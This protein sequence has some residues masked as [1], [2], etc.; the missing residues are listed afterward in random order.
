MLRGA[1]GRSEW[2]SVCLFLSVCSLLPWVGRDILFTP[3]QSSEYVRATEKLET[4]GREALVHLRKGTG[5]E[6][7]M[8]SSV[9]QASDC[10][11]WG[12]LYQ[13]LKALSSGSFSSLKSK[14]ASPHTQ[15]S[16]RSPIQN[17]Q[18]VIV[19]HSLS[20]VVGQIFLFSNEPKFS[21]VK[22][23]TSLNTVIEENKPV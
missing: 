15:F 5:C 8:F 23:D 18:D 22:M 21:W 19:L 2:Q 3:V 16:T 7:S 10:M 12:H 4:P 17:E 6:F 9:Q 1:S 20:W 14:A 11:L 13:K